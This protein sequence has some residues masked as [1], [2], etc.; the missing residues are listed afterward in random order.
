[1]DITPDPRHIESIRAANVAVG[2][3]QTIIADGQPIEVP[4]LADL[5][6]YLA[7]VRTAHQRWADT[8]DDPLPPEGEQDLFI[9]MRA[10]PMRLAPYRP[11]P[12]DGDAPAVDLLTAVRDARRT[13]ILGEPGSGKTA[14]LERLAW[15]TATATLSRAQADPDGA[16]GR[17]PAGAGWPTTAARRT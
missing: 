3:P 4:T 9:A 11:Q 17:A 14:A 10:L 16:A 1:M 5:L 8:P 15:V 7:N 12:A 13:F 2:G 6:A